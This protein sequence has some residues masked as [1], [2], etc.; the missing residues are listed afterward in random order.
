MPRKNQIIAVVIKQYATGLYR[1]C[2]SLGRDNITYLG[3]HKDERSA[4]EALN[5]FWRA[6]DEGQL[7]TPED[8]AGFIQS[9]EIKP[10]QHIPTGSSD[11]ASPM[12]PLSGPLSSMQQVFSPLAA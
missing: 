6:W 5:H 3:T 11:P 9:A 4:N 1:T 8:V 12:G 7:K 2:V 10:F